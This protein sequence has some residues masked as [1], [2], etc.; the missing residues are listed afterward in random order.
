MSKTKMNYLIA[1]KSPDD[2]M[3]TKRKVA[4]RVCTL[5]LADYITLI[6]NR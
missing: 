2:M 6:G 3:E 1:N 4:H 5:L